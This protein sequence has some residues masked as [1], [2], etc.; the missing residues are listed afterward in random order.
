[1]YMCWIE[2]DVRAGGHC[3]E[4][5]SFSAQWC[6]VCGRFLWGLIRQGM[7]CRGEGGRG[8]SE[9]DGEGGRGNRWMDRGVGGG[10]G[11]EWRE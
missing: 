7:K 8:G 9:G 2:G 4:V 5:H 3:F 11:R 10:G 6:D 1:M